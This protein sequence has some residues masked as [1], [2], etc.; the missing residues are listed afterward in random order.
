MAAFG[1][2]PPYVL[3]DAFAT[4]SAPLGGVANQ[5]PDDSHVTRLKAA[6]RRAATSLRL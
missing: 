3:T 4:Q 2:T 6:R 1:A 5:D